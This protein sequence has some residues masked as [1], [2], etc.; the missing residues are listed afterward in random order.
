LFDLYTY[1]TPRPF[2]QFMMPAPAQNTCMRDYARVNGFN[3]RLS[4]LELM[5]DNCYAQLF[6]LI[7]EMPSNSNICLYSILLLPLGR[8]LK[9]QE[10]LKLLIS[11]NIKSHFIFE[12]IV[13]QDYI[14]VQ[15]YLASIEFSSQI[16]NENLNDIQDV[17][18]S[19]LK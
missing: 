19:L 10:C 2:G 11:K 8:A 13:T 1:S 3:F 9:L 7:N 5:Y 17:F 6:R 4:V 12:K 16:L 18:N 14:E 15:S